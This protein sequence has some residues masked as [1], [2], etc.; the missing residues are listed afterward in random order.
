MLLG[1]EWQIPLKLMCQ[2]SLIYGGIKPKIYDQ[3][4][5][6]F[7]QTYGAHHLI[8]FQNLAKLKLL[9]SNDSQKSGFSHLSKRLSLLND[10]ES[11]ASNTMISYAY[12][13][14][15][16]I[17]LRLLEAVTGTLNNNDG[18]AP[19]SWKGLEDVT[20]L[21]PGKTFEKS[22]IPVSKLFKSES[23]R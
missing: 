4:R 21:L 13:G 3:F 14:Y 23:I 18:K 8:T 9:E 19:L 1:S 16:P 15:A 6:D 11:T 12:S 7:C 10:Y 20:E 5:K 22:I 17:S 2:Y